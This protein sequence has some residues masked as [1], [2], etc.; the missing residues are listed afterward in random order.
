MATAVDHGRTALTAAA[1]AVAAGTLV[2]LGFRVPPRRLRPTVPTMDRGEVPLPDDLPAPV[3]RHYRAAGFGGTMV[4]RVDTF[5]LWGWGRMKLN[6]MPWIPVTY[7]SEHRVGWSGRQRLAVTWYTIPL[8]RAVSD[9]VGRHGAMRV[10]RHSTTGPEIDQGENLFLWAEVVLIP[11]VLATRPGVHW[12]PV[13]EHTARLRV[14]FGAGE[15]ELEFRFDPD[16]GLIG[17]CRALRYRV[18]GQ[19][20]VGWHIGYDSWTPVDIGMI[21][22]RIAVRWEDH[23]RP[24]FILDVDGFAANVP[25]AEDLTAR[26]R[27]ATSTSEKHRS[28]PVAGERHT[29]GR[30]LRSRRGPRVPQ[31]NPPVGCQMHHDR[32]TDRRDDHRGGAEHFL[33]DLR[34]KDH[35]TGERK[36]HRARDELE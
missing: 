20:K 15:D 17:E 3:A 6:R 1:T 5:A 34:N 14:P 30:F 33:H 36:H 22:A 27:T 9:Y 10:G 2:W 12:E 19:P 8:L 11:A 4:P 13:D 7:R 32:D 21:P 25:V 23:E 31:P 28:V 16:T 26:D 24:W 35:G 29:H 18:P